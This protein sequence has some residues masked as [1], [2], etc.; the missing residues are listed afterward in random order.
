MFLYQRVS[1]WQVACTLSYRTEKTMTLRIQ[2]TMESELVA[3][4]LAGRIRGEQVPVLRELLKSETSGHSFVLD[5][6]EVRLVDRDA[7]K[8]LAQIEAEGARLK[9]CPA[10][11]REWILQERHGTRRTEA[12]HPE[13]QG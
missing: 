7:V 1:S 11:I 6:K 10:F 13:V 12:G 5:L 9:N 4:E 8:F 3:L 2:R